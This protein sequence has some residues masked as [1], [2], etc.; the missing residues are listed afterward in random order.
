M[1]LNVR[2][3]EYLQRLAIG[4]GVDEHEAGP[5]AHLH[6]GQRQ[7][8]AWSVGEVPV[9]GDLLQLAIDVPRPTVKRATKLAHAPV[10]RLQQPA[11]M[12]AGIGISLDLAVT[13]P[14]DQVRLVGNVV[15]D[16]AA[17]MG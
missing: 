11:A 13:Y 17:R 7:V 10:I 5:G 3:E 1:L 15:D 12:Q 6:F 16:V 4:V 2:A 9:G 8:A 14:G